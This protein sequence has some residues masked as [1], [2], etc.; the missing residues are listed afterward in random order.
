MPGES[1]RLTN[2]L[3]LPAPIVAAVRNDRYDSGG[4]DIS[5]TTLLQPPRKVVLER[6][7]SNE[8]EED[9]MDR[10]WSLVGQVM[11]GILER[12]SPSGETEKRYFMKMRDWKVSGQIDRIEDGILQ[13]Y[14]FVTVYKVRDGV[15]PD[16]EAQMNCYAELLRR[17]GI[18]VRRLE[19]VAILRDWS[20]MEARREPTYPQ[21]QVLIQNV[22][23]WTSAEC[24]KFL[25][26]RVDAHQAAR[27]LLPECTPEERWERPTKWAVMKKGGVRAVKLHFIEK[28]AQ[29]H[30]AT[31]TNLS[32]E[33]RPG[34]S[35]R[36]AAYCSAAPFCDQYQKNLKKETL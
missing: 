24:T 5:I 19:L 6:Q 8:L 26:D 15:D 3:N 18:E 23:L 11:H 22:R 25:E 17:N 35:V 31:A 33:V 9:V 10:I 7:H 21:Q 2:R 1:M 27:L 4:A 30:A 29:E 36:C 12:A 32:V 20:K 13:D 16:Y 34:D 28:N 14:K